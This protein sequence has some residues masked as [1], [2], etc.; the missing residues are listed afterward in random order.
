MKYSHLDVLPIGLEVFVA[1]GVQLGH[2]NSQVGSLEQILD[3]LRI[4]IE[5]GTV[6]VDVGRQDSVDHGAEGAG[7][8]LGIARLAHGLVEISRRSLFIIRWLLMNAN[9][10][11]NISRY[12]FSS[13][14][15]SDFGK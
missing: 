2:V 12:G 11:I 9:V 1:E 5:A 14:Y 10:N 13:T 3:L 15:H 4:R 7:H 6:D 8:N